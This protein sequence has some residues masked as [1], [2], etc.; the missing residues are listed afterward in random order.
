[1]HET[2]RDFHLISDCDGSCERGGFTDSKT[3]RAFR[4]DVAR[5]RWVGPT[6]AAVGPAAEQGRCGELNATGTRVPSLKNIAKKYNIGSAERNG[7]SA[8]A[9]VLQDWGTFGVA[10]NSGMQPNSP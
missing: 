9:H 4:F 1:V 10:N 2:S 6:R 8:C 3:N 7:T 5:L